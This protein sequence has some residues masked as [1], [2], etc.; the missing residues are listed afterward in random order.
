MSKKVIVGGVPIGGGAP[1]SI[2]SMLNVETTDVEAAVRQIKELEAVGCDLV[3]LAVP[4]MEGAEAFGEIR[5][6]VSLPL[7]ADI[8]FDYRL[9]VRAI[10]LGADKVRINPGNIGSRD[11]VEA[12]VAAAKERKIPIRI[13][14]NAG[15]LEKDILEKYGGATA[16]GLVESALRNVALLEEMDFGDMVLSLKSS[17]VPMNHRAYLS[18]AEKTDYPLHIGVTEAGTPEWGK[19]KSAVGIGA[20]L[21]SGVG[22][23]LRV[24]LTGDPVEEVL[25]GRKI[26]ATVGLRKEAINF[27]SCPTCGRTGVDLESIAGKIEKELIPLGKQRE[28][29]GLPGITIAVM[30]CE[31]NG[32]G[33][34]AGAD[35]GVACGKGK[36]VLF[37]KGKSVK[38][39]EEKDIIGELI[40]LVEEL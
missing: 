28:M 27:V 23:T 10:E 15:S 13:G 9:A 2:Q 32:P 21:L 20:L 16:E 19:I 14:V 30:G 5:R 18:I 39:V 34:A 22:D 3:R 37:A 24:S 29:L 36:G 31:V 4:H 40:K 38:T 11:R 6:R 25:V 33:E 8:H 35:A 12:I 1:I 7:I 17:H 26:L